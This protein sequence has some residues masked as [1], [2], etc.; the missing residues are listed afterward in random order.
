M[1]VCQWC[2]RE[3]MEQVSCTVEFYLFGSGSYQRF[4]VGQGPD[5]RGWGQ[6]KCGDCGA[7]PGG[8]H[9]PGC[10]MESCPQ[11]KHQAIM[12]LCPDIIDA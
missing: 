12:C 3:M 10:D 6:V 2:Q 8:F 1:A 11:C 4:R 7:P 5:D 9:H